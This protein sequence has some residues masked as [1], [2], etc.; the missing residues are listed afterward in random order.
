MKIK[1]IAGFL[2]S[3]LLVYLSLRGIDFHGVARA[4]AT[5][6]YGYALLFL[7]II[8]LI[9]V[10]RSV[11]WGLIL[12]PL[13]PIDQLTLFSV[14]NVGFLAIA[15]V[16]ARLGE[17]ARP[18]LITRRSPVTMTSAVGTIFLERICDSLAVLLIALLT[19]F[20][21][22]LPP[23]LTRASLGFFWITVAMAAVILFLVIRRDLA[24]KVLRLF[25]CRLPGEW[26]LLPERMLHQ[27]GEGFSVFRSPRLFL[28]TILLTVVI[29]L[30]DV[31]AIYV[32][33]LAFG[34]DLPAAAAV[35]VM[36]VLIVGIAIPTAPGFVGNWH[37]FCILA[38]GVFGIPKTEALSFAI[39]YHFLS[40]G[41]LVVLGL[42]FLPFNPFSLSS[43]R[44][45]MGNNTCSS[46]E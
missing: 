8:F 18:Y 42:A 23:W 14:S 3:A 11:R 43:L 37:F 38:L 22:V 24:L 7:A 9:Q 28:L 40:I 2:V 36:I 44:T 6:R 29:W 16:P 41:M 12:R 19:P 32:M 34:L 39:I 4:M 31:L 1:L 30:V 21:M 10:L 25:L 13:A 26:G 17:L 33:F 45:Q 5:L 46:S 27:F 15:A 20:F 35:V